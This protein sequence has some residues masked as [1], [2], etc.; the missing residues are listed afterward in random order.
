M[1]H[2]SPSV[3]SMLMGEFWAKQAGKALS[4]AKGPIQPCR[5][6]RGVGFLATLCWGFIICPN[7]MLLPIVVGYAFYNLMWKI[8]AQLFKHLN[9]KTIALRHF[10]YLISYQS[11]NELKNKQT[12][13]LIISNIVFSYTFPRIMLSSIRGVTYWCILFDRMAK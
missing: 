6:Q 2:Q 7:A 13:A 9:L 1:D 10:P 12:V 4:G 3:H 8:Q 5:S 11:S